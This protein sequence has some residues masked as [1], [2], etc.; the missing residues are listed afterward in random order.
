MPLPVRDAVQRV[1]LHALLEAATE[2]PLTLVSAPAGFGKTTLLTTW[3]AARREPPAWLSA[4]EVEDGAG[5]WTTLARTLE[6]ATGTRRGPV[7]EESPLA[8]VERIAARS[9]RRLVVV[10]DDFHVCRSRA[11]LEPLA[12][13]LAHAPPNLN[14]VLGCRRDPALAL[15]RLRLAGQ[16]TELRA[17]EL[18][19]DLE[20]AVAFVSGAGL[21]LEP[22]LVEA[23][24]E[25]TEGW[26]AALRFAVISMRS[27]R[28]AKPFVL[29]LSRT[30]RALSDYLVAEVLASQPPRMREFLLRTSICDRIDAALADE[31][32]GRRDS[33]QILGVLERDNVLVELEPD[34]RW[35]RYHPLFAELLRAEGERK[36][37]DELPALHLRAARRFDTDGD[38]LAALPHAL[39]GSDVTLA[40]Q[41]VSRLWVEI[42]GRGNVRLARAVLDAVADE[43]VVDHPQLCL[44]AA[45]ERL[46]DGR[47]G[48]A[49]AWLSL[50]DTGAARFGRRRPAFELGRALL[51]A[52]RARLGGDLDVLDNAVER[53]ARPELL[54][55][56][57]GDAEEQWALILFGR[58]VSAVW[59][60]QLDE[61][62]T[63]LEAALDTARRSELRSVE[64]EAT[65]VLALACAF[66]GELK[67]AARLAGTLV[68]RLAEREWQQPEVPALIALARCHLDWGDT[69]E[70]R[71]LAER[72]RE[73]AG[74][75]GDQLGRSAAR[76]V[77]A[78]AMADLPDV[79]GLARIELSALLAEQ[80]APLP[81]LFVPWRDV[82]RAELTGAALAAGER[83]EHGV[84][85]ARAA[86]ARGDES[87]AC[88]LLQPVIAAPPTAT[89]VL[90]EAVVLRGVAADRN[91]EDDEARGWIER[92]L[93]LA[94]PE[95][96]RRPFV[97]VGPEMTRILRRS[98]RHGTAHR[99][100][101]GSLL[102]VLERRDASG[103]RA[104]RELLDPLSERETVVLRY[105]PTLL[106]NQEIAGEL[107]VS[108]NTVKTHLKNIYRKLGVSDRREAVRLAR[109]LR[110][111]G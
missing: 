96:I 71:D 1:R 58:A 56:V 13:L 108:V 4:G 36:L 87:A 21:D 69:E 28:E 31:L 60:G 63:M 81:P 106:S 50:A 82:L 22:E 88:E 49:E 84:A 107:Y 8:A 68:G 105:L 43:A 57:P 61:A 99:W 24:L 85:A 32:T 54:P 42:E 103:D 19:F 5:F 66:R 94:E 37:R 46:R 27:S 45:W 52:R 18:A 100:L 79:D 41:L 97:G 10:V 62:V 55:S 64:A 35:Y 38:R 12:R 90:V 95:T 73:L 3:A 92:A 110:L 29:A 89:P 11:V 47:V 40:A 17:R 80:T 34:G 102:A 86:L 91:G 53:L 67:R 6:A 104:A 33:A 98:I 16:I 2:R 44:L 59:H 74:R 7:P 15:H 75:T 70:A 20:E 77:S 25:R 51:E 23:L 93:E 101:A 39:A 30:D 76:L 48:E 83:P 72:A 14:V 78:R 111:V 9:T 26:A 65:A 109:D